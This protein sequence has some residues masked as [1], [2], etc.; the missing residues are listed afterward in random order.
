MNHTQILLST[1]EVVLG[2]PPI[3]QLAQISA[4]C[5]VFAKKCINLNTARRGG[6]RIGLYRGMA[7]ASQKR[8]TK[9]RSSRCLHCDQ[10]VDH[11]VL[12][13]MDKPSPEQASRLEDA[14]PPEPADKGC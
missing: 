11:N 14:L 1:G 13:R 6:G 3:Q 5:L 10:A 2:E 4:E 12:D 7:T 9:E 8:A